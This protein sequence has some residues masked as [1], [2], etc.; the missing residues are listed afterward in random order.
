[1]LSHSIFRGGPLLIWGPKQMPDFPVDKQRLLLRKQLVMFGFKP[2]T[3]MPFDIWGLTINCYRSTDLFY[4]NRLKIKNLSMVPCYKDMPSFS[5][6]C[7]TAVPH[8]PPRCA[9]SKQS[10]G[11]ADAGKLMSVIEMTVYRTALL[12]W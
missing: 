10:Q 9:S 8:F 6:S 5:N 12:I 3:S 4:S 7:S 11:P 1:M 2:L